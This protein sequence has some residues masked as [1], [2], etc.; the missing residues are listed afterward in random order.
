MSSSLLHTPTIH[1]TSSC[2][3]VWGGCWVVCWCRGALVFM[4]IIVEGLGAYA[5]AFIVAESWCSL[6]L[7]FS[8]QNKPCKQWLIGLGAGDG[9]SVVVLTV[10]TGR[11]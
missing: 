7:S 11:W 6:P 5:A 4:I 10:A 2:S 3:Q 8:C 9:S 1:P